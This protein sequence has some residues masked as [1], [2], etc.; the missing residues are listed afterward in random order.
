M[1]TKP[2]R[3]GSDVAAGTDPEHKTDRAVP[4]SEPSRQARDLEVKIG[5]RRVSESGADL[6]TEER[7][8]SASA[9]SPPAAAADR[10]PTPASGESRT[11]QEQARENREKD[12]PA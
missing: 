11:G 8:P 4:E 3:T 5:D 12:P 10:K 1:D 9:G 6:G 7:S 2:S